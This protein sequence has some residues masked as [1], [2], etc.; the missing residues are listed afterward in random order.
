MI[1][2]ALAYQKQ[3]RRVLGRE[4]AYVEMGR[5]DPIVGCTAIPPRPIIGATC[6]R[7]CSH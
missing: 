2:A 3:R 7:T 4:T 6:Y 5:G 1:S